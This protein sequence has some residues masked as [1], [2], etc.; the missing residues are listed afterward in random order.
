MPAFSAVLAA[1]RSARPTAGTT[2]GASSAAPNATATPGRPPPFI[3]S[4]YHAMTGSSSSA[5]DR[6]DR[7]LL[8]N[9]D[10]A[11]R[12][13]L[14]ELLDRVLV[15]RHADLEGTLERR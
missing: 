5:S 1:G 2:V 10:D 15:E 6:L 8:Q 7:G 11:G 9:V 14:L 3:T 12:G 4:S 13:L